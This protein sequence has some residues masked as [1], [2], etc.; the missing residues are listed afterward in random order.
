MTEISFTPSADVS[1]ALNALLDILERRTE[2]TTRSIKVSL[3]ALSLPGYFSQANPEPRLLANEQFN[4]L[5]KKGLLELTW[6]PGE[7]G[8]LLQSITLPKTEYGIRST[9]IFQLLARTPIARSR[10]RLE[11]LLL[12]DKF[13]FQEDWRARAISHILNQLKEEKSPAP[14]SLTDSNLNLDLL[15]VLQVLPALTAETPYRAF[16]VRVFNDTK[17]FEAVKNHIVSLARFGTPEWKRIPAEEV[18]RELNLVANPSYI[19]LSGDW[20]LVTTNGEILDLS[21]FTPS[22]GIPAAQISSLQSVRAESVLCIE[23][24]TTFHQQVDRY[25]PHA[26][27]KHFM[28]RAGYTGK[29]VNNGTSNLHRAV[30][31]IYGNPSPAIR[32]LL[33]LLPKTTPISLW[34]D[35]DYG[36]FN[37]LSQLRRTVGEEIRPYLMDID[38]LEANLPRARPLT[39]SDK[40]NLKRLSLRPELCD[41]RP[42]I[43]HML[44]RGVKLEQEGIEEF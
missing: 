12:A 19:H 30:I 37:I 27:L 39:A 17:R 28:W 40:N 9:E 21:G 7:T 8:H 26:S 1:V 24:L 35:L 16:S 6:I 29:H 41:I 33:R 14:F 4:L 23:N 34:S 43:A 31:C 11:S 13:R 3:A 2:L 18:L 42:V 25:T 20:Q 22:I 44:K 15:A 5:E 32:R 38:A 10:S 36:G